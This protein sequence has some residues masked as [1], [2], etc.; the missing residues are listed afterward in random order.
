M[1]KF[2]GIHISSKNPKRLTHFYHDILGWTMVGDN[3]DYD[4]VR[5]EGR[6]DNPIVWIWDE[7]KHG[8]MNE[9]PVYF[10]FDCPDPDAMHRDLTQKGIILDPPKMAPWGGK[11]LFVID[12]DG[13]KLLMVE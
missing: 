7:S 11:E 3:P 1:I 5:F 13:N 2:S 8:K 6:D 12:P 9:G 4:G 10:T